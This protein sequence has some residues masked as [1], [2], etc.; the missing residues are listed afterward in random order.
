MDECESESSSRRLGLLTMAER[1]TLVGGR[2]EV[3]SKVGHG[4]TVYL[5]L[6]LHD[7]D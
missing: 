4:T 1:A 5:R 7:A 3:E 2:L 6:P